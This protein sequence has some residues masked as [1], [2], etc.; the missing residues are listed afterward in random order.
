MPRAM[1]EAITEGNEEEVEV[2]KNAVAEASVMITPCITV[3]G[4]VDI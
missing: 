4:Q 1:S 3:G 2:S